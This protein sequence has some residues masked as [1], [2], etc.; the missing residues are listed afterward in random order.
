[1]HSVSGVSGVSGVNPT[2]QQ[3]RTPQVSESKH[4][5][6]ANHPAGA[7][8]PEAAGTKICCDEC[9]TTGSKAATKSDIPQPVAKQQHTPP[10][11]LTE[12]AKTEMC[13]IECK[14]TGVKILPKPLPKQ[15]TQLPHEAGKTKRCCD[16]CGNTGHEAIFVSDKASKDGQGSPLKLIHT[17]KSDQE[18]PSLKPILKEFLTSPIRPKSDIEAPTLAL[19]EKP[20]AGKEK[21]ET[22]AP[23]KTNTQGDKPVTPGKNTP[24]SA[25]AEGLV[26]GSGTNTITLGQPSE[27]QAPRLTLTSTQD[28]NLRLVFSQ[29]QFTGSA[30]VHAQGQSKA[31][32][33]TM[34][35]AVTTLANNAATPGD[36]IVAKNAIMATMQALPTEAQA[37]VLIALHTLSTAAPKQFAQITQVL[38]KMASTDPKAVKDLATA[39]A[40]TMSETPLLASTITQTLQ[41]VAKT[42]PQ[43][44]PQVHQDI[45]TIITTTMTHFQVALPPKNGDFSFK[46]LC[47][48]LS[49]ALSAAEV[50]VE[51]LNP[52]QSQ[53]SE[54]LAKVATQLSQIVAAAQKDAPAILTTLAKMA[55]Q[56]PNATP[57]ITQTLAQVAKADAGSLA[58]VSTQLSQIIEST[59]THLQ[60]AL[61]PANENISFKGLCPLNPVQNQNTE[62]F[63]KVTT[64]LSQIVAAAPKE[65]PAILTSVAKMTEQ[66]PKATAAI[67]QTLAQVAQSDANALAKVATQLSQIVVAAPKEAPAILTS[68]AKMTEQ[69][70]KATATITQTLAQVA[71]SDAGALAKVATQLSQIVAATMTHVQVALPPEHADF[72]FK[73]LRGSLS[74]ALSAAEVSVEGLNPVQSQNTETVAKV[75]TQLSQI[76]AAAPK[77]TPQVLLGLQTIAENAPASLSTVINTIATIATLAPA[78]TSS[79]MTTLSQ[80]AQNNHAS[81]AAVATFVTEVATHT[82][83]QLPTVLQTLQSIATQQPQSL[84]QVTQTLTQ[85]IQQAPT[86]I[87]HV[88]TAIGQIAQKSDVHTTENVSKIIEQTVSSKADSQNTA[89]VSTQLS[90][91][92]ETSP[93]EARQITASIA[94]IAQQDVSA[95]AKTVATLSQTLDATPQNLQPM[96]TQIASHVV[97]AVQLPVVMSQMGKVLANNLPGS[98]KF[99][100]SLSG[101]LTPGQSFAQQAT[102]FQTLLLQLAQFAK[103]GIDISALKDFA[104]NTL[105]G[106]SKVDSPQLQ[107]LLARAKNMGPEELS[108]L[109]AQYIAGLEQDELDADKKIREAEAAKAAEHLE[110]NE[111]FTEALYQLFNQQ[112]MENWAAAAYFRMKTKKQAKDEE[113]VWHQKGVL[114]T[115]R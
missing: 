25:K 104:L 1:M 90:Q 103:Q 76:V 72:S 23:Q 91:I 77:D 111:G 22:I 96:M 74:P 60:V 30:L 97:P 110:E 99:M 98:Q 31:L 92:V 50:S 57:A 56:S 36:R 11:N 54:T 42:M 88:A 94:Q 39:L 9:Q 16:A 70:P 38:Q 37:P 64:Q 27:I 7:I 84:P 45:A 59:M 62:T 52:V 46:G 51:G 107:A 81:T 6:F 80:T 93:K 69:S 86:M 71:Q 5:S 41:A 14:D 34:G 4:P 44:L 47:G 40:K 35:K 106:N 109:V 48:S 58:K 8:P 18:K 19:F 17:L 12:A 83:Q 55:E 49:P 105:F 13:C 26:S 20:T 10:M 115:T 2:I 79:A 66:S 102:R 68:V 113:A 82:P 61:P 67:A 87:A 63:A 108:A 100:Q 89:T 28:P 95:A 85:V 21:K 112:E 78:E 53:N 65:A 24:S 15:D 32:P 33:E 29:Q 73:G 75:T 101:L 3:N 43:A 114:S